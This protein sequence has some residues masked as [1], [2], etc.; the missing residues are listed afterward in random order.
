MVQPNWMGAVH[1]GFN[2][3]GVSHAFVVQPNGWEPFMCGSTKLAGA[4]HVWFNETVR[5]HACEL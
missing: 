3:T 4:V 5:S 2:R 1:V